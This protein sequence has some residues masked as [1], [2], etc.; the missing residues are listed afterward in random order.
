[1][2]HSLIQIGIKR[3]LEAGLATKA[4][5]KGC[6]AEEIKKLERALS[7]SL[8]TCYR[9]FLAA[10]GKGAGDFLVGTDWEY[11]LL[12]ELQ[13]DAAVLLVD[14]GQPALAPG[15]FVFSMHQGY[16]FLCFHCDAGPDPPVHLFNEGETA[17]Q[18]FDSFGEWFQQCVEDEVAG[19]HNR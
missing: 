15:S 8:P 16:N 12:V 14:C 11:R 13:V 17:R 7:V 4:I 3:L 2:P 18:V 10:C 19:H 5:L 9:E 1:M 6:S